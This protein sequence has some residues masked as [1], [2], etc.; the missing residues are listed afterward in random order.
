MNNDCYFKFSPLRIKCHFIVSAGGSL[1]FLFGDFGPQRADGSP[2]NTC[3]K[4]TNVLSTFK[5]QV[6]NWIFLP[7]K[8][9]LIRYPIFNWFGPF[10]LSL[11]FNTFGLAVR[12][13]VGWPFMPSRWTTIYLTLE[14]VL[15]T[16]LFRDAKTN[17]IL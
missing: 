4:D 1:I 2:T 8:V 12:T 7:K 14:T 10:G 9:N 16:C 11:R 17:A 6:V 3:W 13:H 5:C 15:F